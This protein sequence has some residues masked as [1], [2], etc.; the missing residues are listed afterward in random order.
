MMSP[1]EED[2]QTSCVGEEAGSPKN[3]DSTAMGDV[4]GYR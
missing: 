2:R 4:G 1:G 3:L